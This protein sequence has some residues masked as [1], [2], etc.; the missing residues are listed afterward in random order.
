[1]GRFQVTGQC[2]CSDEVKIRF[3]NFAITVSP[4]ASLGYT[5]LIYAE[6]APPNWQTWTVAQFG[7]ETDYYDHICSC[8]L[9]YFGLSPLQKEC[10]P[11]REQGL[12][13]ND[14]HGG[15]GGDS[16]RPGRMRIAARAICVL[17]MISGLRG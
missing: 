17:G 16:G 9:I 10:L 3:V 7:I 11:Q 13:E 6:T 1:M 4:S 12:P 15:K 14:D 8:N 5:H 2:S